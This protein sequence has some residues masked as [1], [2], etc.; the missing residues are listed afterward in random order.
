MMFDDAERAV[1]RHGGAVSLAFVA[2]PRS[3]DL[4]LGE[5]PNDFQLV[6]ETDEKNRQKQEELEKK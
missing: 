5:D 1:D 6:G 3:G 2:K 4:G